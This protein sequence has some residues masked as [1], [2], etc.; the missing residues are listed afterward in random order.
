M[1]KGELRSRLGNLENLEHDGAY[2]G[3]ELGITGVTGAASMTEVPASGGSGGVTPVHDFD[4]AFDVPFT[5]MTKEEAKVIGGGTL[6]YSGVQPLSLGS[7]DPSVDVG[8]VSEELK[9]PV[10]D[11]DEAKLA[12]EA[13]TKGCVE[14]LKTAIENALND[15]NS[16]LRM[17]Q[18]GE[19]GDAE[20][21]GGDLAAGNANLAAFAAGGGF[22]AVGS[23]AMAAA[24]GADADV[25]A[26]ISFEQWKK[27]KEEK[28]KA[29]KEAREKAEKEAKDAAAEERRR[30]RK[31]EK[32]ELK[33]DEDLKGFQKGYKVRADGS[34][35]SYFDR[36]HVIDAQTKA[37]LDA[38]K[39]PKRLSVG[40]A[41]PTEAEAEGSKAGSA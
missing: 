31:A 10:G 6:K 7:S 11:T 30:A 1:A 37:L 36:S 26:P 25:D 39:A 2:V 20:A 29:E 3:L 13:Q 5:V 19:E 21:D 38:Q 28:D 12:T 18:G 22:G 35:T 8:S 16:A 33:N 9:P 27:E 40:K 34:K 23:A 14:L 32:I 17:R 4:F 15:F 24:A 41:E